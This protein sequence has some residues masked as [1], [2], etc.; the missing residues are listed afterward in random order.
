[1]FDQYVARGRLKQ[2][3]NRIL[4]KICQNEQTEDWAQVWAFQ[5]RVCDL[6]GKGLNSADSQ[7]AKRASQP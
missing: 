1:M 3:R 2:G 6:A 7:V 5:F 4:L